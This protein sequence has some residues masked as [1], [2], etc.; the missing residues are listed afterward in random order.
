MMTDRALD[1]QRRDD[2]LE[3]HVLVGIGLEQLGAH[4]REQR[5]EGWIPV[6]LRAEREGVDEHPDQRLG[7]DPRAAGDGR[8]HHEI[9]LAAVAS[10]Q[11]LEGREQRHVDRR[12]PIAAEGLQGLGERPIQRPRFARSP[13]SRLAGDTR[14]PVIRRPF[15]QRRGAGQIIDPV[16]QALLDARLLGRGA[17][18]SRVIRIRHRQ[19][20]Q[21]GLSRAIQARVV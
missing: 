19:R 1:V 12:T 2:A 3:G 15:Q 18:R 17:L 10:Q 11:H 8:T 7:L 6:Q 16:L 4:A 14:P 9:V 13:L 5:V 21:L 20:G